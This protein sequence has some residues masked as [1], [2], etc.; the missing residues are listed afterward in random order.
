MIMDDHEEALL[1]TL[2][3]IGIQRP[4]GGVEEVKHV[5]E[6]RPGRDRLGAVGRLRF[7]LGVVLDKLGSD[8]SV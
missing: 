4:I 3:F 7:T 5:D 8:K 1:D 2:P 6:V